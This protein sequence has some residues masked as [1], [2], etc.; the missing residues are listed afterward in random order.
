M[1]GY[2]ITE[3]CPGFLPQKWVDA[4]LEATYEG[5]ESVQRRQLAVTMTSELFL[6]QLGEW[7]DEMRRI[8]SEKPGTGA[9]TLGSAMELW[10]WTLR[11]LRQARD[12][13]GEAIYRDRRQG[14]TFP[15]A[16]A[17]CWLLGARFQILDVLELEAKGGG[18]PGVAEG[19]PGWVQFLTDLCH[20][21]S[22]RAAGEVGRICAELVFG[23]QRHPTWDPSCA[24]CFGA[25]EVDELEGL[26]PGFAAGTRG[27]G[28]VLESD[29]SHPAKAGPC[30]RFAG[31]ETFQRMRGKLDG[32]LVGARLAK[33]RAGHALTEV[34]IPEA[35]DYPG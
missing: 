27:R 5:P 12:A 25:D 35:L 21:Q 17:L 4:Q 8:A 18:N 9:C 32:C 30:V 10:L 31:Y 14:A 11:Y 26:M 3:D 22:A 13:D 7:A 15:M 19:L 6:A 29:G 34:T 24:S 16:D 20:V 33:D 1:G 28:E 2:G 23:Y